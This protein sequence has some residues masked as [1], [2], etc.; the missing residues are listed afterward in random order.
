MP[1]IRTLKTVYK[2]NI[3]VK[4]YKKPNKSLTRI[5]ENNKQNLILNTKYKQ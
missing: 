4:L 2:K 5:N 3:L 1:V